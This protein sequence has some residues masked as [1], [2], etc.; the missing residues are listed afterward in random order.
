M[1]WI[2]LSAFHLGSICRLYERYC[3]QASHIHIVIGNVKSPYK[4][5][6][7]V[8]FSYMVRR[9]MYHREQHLNTSYNHYDIF[10]THSICQIFSGHGIFIAYCCTMNSWHYGKTLNHYSDITMTAMA[11]QI[12]GVSTVCSTVCSGTDKRKHQSSAPKAFVGVIHRWPMDSPHK[13][14]V[15]RKMFPFDGIIIPF[16]LRI[17]CRS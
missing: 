11:S 12:T 17:R 14:S 1:I 13:G 6:D 4:C 9:K 3:I 15:T 2:T 7:V 10:S 8:L 5:Y 16:W